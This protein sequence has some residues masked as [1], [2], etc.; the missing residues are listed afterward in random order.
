MS[1]QRGK[2]IK[3]LILLVTIVTTLTLIF[4]NN[5]IEPSMNISDEKFKCISF[6]KASTNGQFPRYMLQYS[7]YFGGSVYDEAGVR[8][9]VDQDGCPWI[10][11]YGATTDFPIVGNF[12]N[13]TPVDYSIIL[14]K[15]AP[16]G[17]SILYSTYLTGNFRDYPADMVIDANGDVWITGRTYSTDFPVTSNA[18]N[19]TYTNISFSQFITEGFLC[20]ISGL[21]GSLQYSSYI[22]GDSVDPRAIAIDDSGYIWIAGRTDSDRF[23]ITAT[24]VDDTYAGGDY[25][26][27]LSQFSPDGERLLFSTFIGG[28]ESEDIKDIEI[29]S[30]GDVWVTGFTTSG[31]ASGF[32]I[33]DNALDTSINGNSDA[34]VYELDTENTKFPVVSYCSYLGGSGS[35]T[36]RS[37]SMDS[38]GIYIV[39]DT[40]SA[41]FPTVNALDNTH[42]GGKDLFVFK[43]SLKGDIATLVNSTYIGGSGS[44]YGYSSVLDN[45]KNLWIT[46]ETFSTDFPI[47]GGYDDT[48]VPP[49]SDVFVL[50]L[51][52][53]LDEIKYSTFL[54][55]PD[56][57]Q[58]YSLGYDNV[59]DRIWVTGLGMIGFP[60]VNGYDIVFDGYSEIFVIYQVY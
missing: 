14:M 42:G 59:N 60:I 31:R 52:N 33:T 57:D 5:P 36:A 8:I 49:N 35:D 25:D 55:G 7:S 13:S 18:L 41:D 24:A 11:G 44:E 53:K 30:A 39:G 1:S 23:P 21:D 26:G 37:I 3:Y 40:E 58:A 51:S 56:D 50:R 34:F 46:G 45:E 20:K 28:K 27:F 4:S 16:D 43:M 19:S 29:D 48:L 32:P 12:I 6:A 54:G 15:L 17:E 47:V 9:A 38:R 22:G 10:L 2:E